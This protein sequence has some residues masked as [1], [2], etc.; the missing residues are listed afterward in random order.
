MGLHRSPVQ[1]FSISPNGLFIASGGADS[2][3][4]IWHMRGG[5]LVGLYDSSKQVLEDTE[6]P[7][8]TQGQ[9]EDLSWDKDGKHLAV[10][11]DSQK[12]CSN[13]S[14]PFTFNH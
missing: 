2:V 11:V 10:A 3:V 9:I 1:T 13:Q 6:I 14:F 7:R 4:M 8:D 12:V 5:D